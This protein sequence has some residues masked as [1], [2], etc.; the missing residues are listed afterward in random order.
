M[1]CG[2]ARVA[3]HG[4]SIASALLLLDAVLLPTERAGDSR[5]PESNLMP[6]CKVHSVSVIRALL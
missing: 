6:S 4:E 1:I 3:R 2:T 5:N